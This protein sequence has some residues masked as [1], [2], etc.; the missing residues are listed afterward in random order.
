MS[1]RA[2]PT[3][4]HI[5]PARHP[6]ARAE[7]KTI[8]SP[9]LKYPF[10]GEKGAAEEYVTAAVRAMS[11]PYIATVFGETNPAGLAGLSFLGSG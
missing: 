9:R 2:D 11:T 8:E 4:P 1:A 3:P 5:A 10:V 7:K 6:N